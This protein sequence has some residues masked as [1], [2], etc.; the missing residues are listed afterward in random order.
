MTDELDLICSLENSLRELIKSLAS[1]LGLDEGCANR[2]LNDLTRMQG[3]WSDKELVPKR[4]A[5]LLVNLEGQILN[6][7]TRYAGAEKDKIL[8]FGSSVG[9]AT[10]SCFCP[11]GGDL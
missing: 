7:A 5:C 6:V 3:L 10:T 11:E 8:E 9:D 4:A 2:V 1:G